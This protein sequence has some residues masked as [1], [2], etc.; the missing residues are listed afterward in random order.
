MSLPVDRACGRL[1]ERGAPFEV[2]QV[3]GL[4]FDSNGG[5]HL[6][7]SFAVG[8]NVLAV[9][10][11]RQSD[12]GADEEEYPPVEADDIVPPLP[13][14]VAGR[15]VVAGE[16]VRPVVHDAADVVGVGGEAL[17]PAHHTCTV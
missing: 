14:G 13:P 2:E 15:L 9:P 3:V 7:L 8:S 12:P 16:G 4:K 11:G 10:A 5:D 6:R 17:V 1:D